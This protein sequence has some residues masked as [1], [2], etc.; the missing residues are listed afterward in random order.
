ME[1]W[2]RRCLLISCNTIWPSDG[3]QGD[4]CDQSDNNSRSLTFCFAT[5]HLCSPRADIVSPAGPHQDGQLSPLVLAS[6]PF[7]L[8]TICFVAPFLHDLVFSATSSPSCSSLSKVFAAVC[9]RRH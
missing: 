5:T 4:R 2:I 8:C 7:A 6:S 9:K 1:R 3:Y